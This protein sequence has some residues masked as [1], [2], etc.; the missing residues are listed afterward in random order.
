MGPLPGWCKRWLL[1]PAP[2]PLLP[3]APSPYGD[4]CRSCKQAAADGA[5]VV[6]VLD[7]ADTALLECVFVLKAL[8]L[9]LQLLV[10]FLQLL[11]M[12]LSLLNN[13]RLESLAHPAPAPPRRL[14]IWSA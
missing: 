8:L 12:S 11:R 5:A 1:L 9:G 10:A 7:R 3:P 2:S 6:V 4:G 14:S 13:P